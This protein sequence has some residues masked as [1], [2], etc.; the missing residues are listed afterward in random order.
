MDD[1]ELSKLA[2]EARSR[3]EDAIKRTIE[4]EL[5]RAAGGLNGGEMM[6]HSRSKGFFFSRSKTSDSLLDR[7]SN[8][9]VDLDR[10]LL[11]NVET[12]DDASFARFADRLST[13]KKVK[14][15]AK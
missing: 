3:V 4:G 8:P 14:P 13:L 6:A 1:Y 2:P 7:V 9:A 5:A 11:R 12:L 15:T 10:A